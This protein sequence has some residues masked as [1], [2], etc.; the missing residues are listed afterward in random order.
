MFGKR[1]RYFAGHERVGQ[2]GADVDI[3]DVH[4]RM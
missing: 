3:V 4:V 1:S 2:A